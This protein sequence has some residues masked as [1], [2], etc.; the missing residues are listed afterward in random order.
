MRNILTNSAGEYSVDGS[1]IL[2][3]EHV[4]QSAIGFL[5]VD[6]DRRWADATT[7]IPL[8]WEAVG[9]CVQGR[10]GKVVEKERAFVCV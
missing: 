9:V 10:E 7:N 8:I 6:L 1:T 2:L 5:V 3:F 4:S